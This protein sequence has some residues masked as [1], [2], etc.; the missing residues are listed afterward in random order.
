MK[1]GEILI[2]KPATLVLQPGDLGL[3]LDALAE[4]PFKKANPVIQTIMGQLALQ[5][6]Q[7]VTPQP[8]IQEASPAPADALN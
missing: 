2:N 8:E 5:A 7:P 4:L 3:V 1:N 6:A